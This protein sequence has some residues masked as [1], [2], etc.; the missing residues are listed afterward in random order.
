MM[1]GRSRSNATISPS[2][3]VS[4][5]RFGQGLDDRRIP[6]AKSLSFRERSCT[7]PSRLNAIAR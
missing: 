4:F 1:V 5:G 7:L 3:T 2:I 6:V